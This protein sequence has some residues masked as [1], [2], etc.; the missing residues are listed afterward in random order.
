LQIASAKSIND[1]EN[2]LHSPK[3]TILNIIFSNFLLLLEESVILSP[4]TRPI[5]LTVLVSKI[6]SGF[7]KAK[8][9]TAE[10]I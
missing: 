2:S 8:Q 6:G 1:N 5:T 3:L 7:S 4:D 10:E 9:T